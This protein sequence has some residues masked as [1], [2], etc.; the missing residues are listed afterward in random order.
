MEGVKQ[1]REREKAEVKSCL[2]LIHKEVLG[3]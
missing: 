2:D 1:N 3:S